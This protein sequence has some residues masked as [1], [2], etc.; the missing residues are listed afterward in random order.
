LQ[1]PSFLSKRVVIRL[2]VQQ[3]ERFGGTDG[4][5][6]EGLLES[7]I[8]QPLATFG[9]QYLHATIYAQAAAYLFHIAMN[10]PCRSGSISHM[11]FK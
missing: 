8:S 10:H 6:D 3:I 5:R 2:H 7:A 4:I 9:G 1:T 11:F